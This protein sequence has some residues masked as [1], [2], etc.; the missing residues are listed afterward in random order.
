MKGDTYDILYQYEN[1]QK[2]Q[3]PTGPEFHHLFG[4]GGYDPF[5]KEWAPLHVYSGPNYDQGPIRAVPFYYRS[6]NGPSPPNYPTSSVFKSVPS[7]EVYE[8]QTGKPKKK[9]SPLKD[10][11]KKLTDYGKILSYAWE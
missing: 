4:Q 3:A 1:Y 9:S 10:F 6:G 8:L 2:A 5:G 7:Y 11:A